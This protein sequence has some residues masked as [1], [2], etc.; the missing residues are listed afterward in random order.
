MNIQHFEKGLHYT[1]KQLLMLAKKVGKLATYCVRL[2]DESSFIRIEA[3]R[4]ETKKDRDAVKVTLT[5]SLPRKMLRVES[6]REE[7]LEGIDRCIEKLEP[8]IKKYKEM[9]T[10]KGRATVDGRQKR[11]HTKGR[12]RE[13]DEDTE[14]R[15]AA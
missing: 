8:Q 11:Q 15:M 10:A 7:V 4:R 12:R 2:K 3:E 1:D 13:K 5:V 9:H 14:R 6:R